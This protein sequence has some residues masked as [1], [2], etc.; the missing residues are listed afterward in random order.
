MSL[1][2]V[3]IIFGGKSVEHEISVI[4]ARSIVKNIDTELYN[5]IS[6]FIDKN[7]VW[8]I[9]KDQSWV[10]GEDLIYENDLYV[11]PSLNPDNPTLCVVRGSSVVEE[12]EI[13]IAFPVLHGTYG[14]DGA[15]QGLFEL[16][17]TP[18]VGAGVLG[19]SVGMDKIMMKAV[20]K[21]AGLPIVDYVWFTRRDW[22]TDSGELV[23]EIIRALGPSVFV[24]SADLGS[25]VGITKAGTE[26]ELRK[27]VEY[28]LQYSDRVIVERAVNDP[29]EIEVS[30][31]GNEEALASVPGEVKPHRE[32]YDYRAKYLEEGTGLVVPAEFSSDR[33]EALKKLAVDTFKT[34]D[35]SGMGRIDF[36]VDGATDEMFVS[37]INTIPGFTEI[38]MYPKL[39]EATGISFTELISRLIDLGLERQKRKK[40]LTRELVDT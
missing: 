25:S 16:M 36:L 21:D 7:G 37:E 9:V 18:Y 22:Q 35:C 27:A 28:S 40:D 13:D 38:S 23:P 11:S 4:S 15:I 1:S 31:L 33:I 10:G 24:K 2:R 32:F 17:G 20:L 5:V 34:L 6:V 8:R 29:R 12:I 19:S 39:W 3:A 14:E 30:V 26:T